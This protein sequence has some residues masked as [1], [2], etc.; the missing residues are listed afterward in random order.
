MLEITFE[1]SVVEF[2]LPKL[3]TFQK[4]SK[5]SLPRKSWSFL[6]TLIVYEFA[7]ASSASLHSSSAFLS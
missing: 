3:L 4:N 5:L 6:Q 1:N 7:V 2:W